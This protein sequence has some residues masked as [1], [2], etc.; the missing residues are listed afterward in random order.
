MQQTI[1][2]VVFTVAH[3]EYAQIDFKS[4]IGKNEIL[5]FD[6]N[7]VLTNKQIQDISHGHYKFAGIGRGGHK[8]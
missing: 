3:K 8:V 5:I 4:W 7:R 6:A 1:F 2:A